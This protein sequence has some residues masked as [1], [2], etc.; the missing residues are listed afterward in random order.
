MTSRL[1][2]SM[3]YFTYVVFLL[4]AITAIIP[5]RATSFFTPNL[6]VLES[7]P[8]VPKEWQQGA[9][10]P[11]S[12]RLKFRI[13]LRQENAFAFEQQ[14]IAMST[15]DH[16]SYGRHMKQHEV[17]RMLQPSLEASGAVL[18]WLTGEGVPATNIRDDG[19]WIKFQ[20]SA[21][22]AER[23]LATRFHYYSN[24]AEKVEIIRTLRYSIPQ[25]L[26]KYVQLI[27]PTTRFAQTQA[28]YS[29]IFDHFAIASVKD[30]Y[31]QSMG[32]D[33]ASCNNT[34]TPQC[35]K[36]L[37]NFGDYQGKA[38]EGMRQNEISFYSVSIFVAGIST[39]SD[40]GM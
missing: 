31:N 40:G 2:A 37:Y 7:L 1:Q 9:A 35:L 39:S 5:S 25:N 15:P 32:L 4:W 20:V 27:Q 16:P 22:E 23:I 33:E 36:D 30:G 34:I 12:K 13:A 11:A 10:V 24:Y 3:L 6:T 29:A 28:Q 38:L 14:V 21:G 26:H 17:R 18:Q 19:D 8:E